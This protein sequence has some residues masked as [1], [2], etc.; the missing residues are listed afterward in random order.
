MIRGLLVVLA[1][2][3]FSPA[4]AKDK[5]DARAAA[6]IQ[7]CVKSK[8]ATGMGETCIGI[9]SGPCLD[10]AADP[11]TAGMVACVARERAVWD[12]ILNETY[13]R[14][15]AKLDD[16]QQQKLRDMQRAWIAARD[17]TCGFYWDFYQGTMASPM[18]AGCVNKETAERALFLLGFLNEAEGK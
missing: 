14:L 11:S 6:A 4:L 17:A 10:K 15:R 16:K 1:A 5:P 13:N 3:A 7:D 8:S 12:D 9:V 2:L 18:S